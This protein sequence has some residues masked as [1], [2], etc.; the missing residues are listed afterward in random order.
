MITFA[1]PSYST[2][3]YQGISLTGGPP[4][5]GRFTSMMLNVLSK[6]VGSKG[7]EIKVDNLESYNF[8][9]KEILREVAPLV[10]LGINLLHRS[11]SFCRIFHNMKSFGKLLRVMD[12][13]RRF[14][15]CFERF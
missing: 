14:D 10:A 8:N 3:S 15:H 12:F 7:L 4:H 1:S 11:A 6:I 2:K 5:V 9:P 13:L